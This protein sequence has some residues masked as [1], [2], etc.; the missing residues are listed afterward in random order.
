MSSKMN[1]LAAYRVHIKVTRRR[2][3]FDP[4]ARVIARS[5][6]RLLEGEDE[7]LEALDIHKTYALT[8]R[9]LDATHAATIATRLCK[10]LLVEPTL[11][12]HVIESVQELVASASEEP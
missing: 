11:E 10:D 6:D 5:I 9:A 8:L 4:A 3:V 12:D 7:A 2:G 1:A